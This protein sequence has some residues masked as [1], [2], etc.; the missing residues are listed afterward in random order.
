MNRKYRKTVIAGNWKMNK[1]PSETK[2]FMTQLKAILPKGRWCDIALCVPAVCIPAAVRA[3]RETRVGIG[4]E[5]CS[6]HPS[7]A[8]TGEIACNMLT[9]AGCKYVIIGHSERRAERIYAKG[10]DYLETYPLHTSTLEMEKLVEAG[11]A[12]AELVPVTAETV[13]QWRSIC[14]ER[15]RTVDNAATLERKDEKWILES[16]G[17]SFIYHKEEMLGIGWIDK[18][19][20]MAVAAVKPGAGQ[21][22]METLFTLMD[23]QVLRLQVASTNAKAIRLYER[24]GFHQTK[25]VS[26][27]YR[28]FP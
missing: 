11:P 14:N 18:G 4:A 21:Q 27:W 6:P 26:R 8:F 3:M 22:I 17:A 16:G 7:G 10:H 20:L 19:E 15:M 9:D 24:L 23:G 12:P 1:T 28:V 13:G 5:N 2:E 25:E